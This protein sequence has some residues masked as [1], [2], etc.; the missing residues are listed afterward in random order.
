M[1]KSMLFKIVW[2]HL[3]KLVVVLTSKHLHFHS[4]KLAPNLLPHFREQHQL[5][6][7][8]TA[9]WHEV[10]AP[11]F[12]TQNVKDSQTQELLWGLQ[13]QI[14]HH[15]QQGCRMD[16]VLP[17]DVGNRGAVVCSHQHVSP[18]PELGSVGEP[19]APPEVW[20][21]WCVKFPVK[22]KHH[23][24][25]LLR[26][27]E[28]SHSLKWAHCFWHWVVERRWQCMQG[29]SYI[30]PLSVWSCPEERFPL[31]ADVRRAWWAGMSLERQF[32]PWRSKNL[33]TED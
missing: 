30:M 29:G 21:G 32:H 20:W 11:V 14:L 25:V 13:Q 23:P 3:I 19:R 17:I 27:S 8:R 7:H 24:S 1:Y 22:A 26:Q 6:C 18:E 15:L 2:L 9:S 28:T 12:Q 16:S 33:L 4:P 31:T 10:G 5:H